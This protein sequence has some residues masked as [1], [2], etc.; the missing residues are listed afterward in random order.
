MSST[1]GRGIVNPVLN[2]WSN[3]YHKIENGIDTLEK[4]VDW[5]YKKTDG[6]IGFILKGAGFMFFAPSLVKRPVNW[7]AYPMIAL[8]TKP[9]GDTYVVPVDLL[10]E[11]GVVILSLNLHHSPNRIQEGTERESKEIQRNDD[12]NVGAN[13]RNIT[14]DYVEE[15]ALASAR[16]FTVLRTIRKLSCVATV[17]FLSR[18][19]S[20]LV[21]KSKGSED[22]AQKVGL[23][24]TYLIP[25]AIS[26]AAPHMEKISKELC[27]K[28]WGSHAKSSNLR[29]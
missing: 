5:V 15:R 16:S 24:A 2:Y 22:T 21:K 29:K 23:M 8:A 13:N 3:N 17:L 28:V 19:S 1:L 6:G 12:D 9:L 4:G 14:G 20:E 27:S 26:R 18:L 7:I 11:L 10:Y 25:M